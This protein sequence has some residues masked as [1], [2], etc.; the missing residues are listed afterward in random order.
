MVQLE[1]LLRQKDEEISR[2]QKSH[3]AKELPL[4]IEA[5]TSPLRSS[6]GLSGQGSNEK[7]KIQHESNITLEMELQKRSEQNSTLEEQLKQLIKDNY[8]LKVQH[9]T[10]SEEVQQ[11]QKQI[12]TLRQ[13]LKLT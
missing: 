7:R 3:D 8:Q 10:D 1:D 9:D 12:A 11:L 13:P 4:L 5:H 2:L 6:Q